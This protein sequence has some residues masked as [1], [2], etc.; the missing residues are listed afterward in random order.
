MTIQG[1]PSAEAHRAHAPA[2]NI[3]VCAECEKVRTILFL[4][5]DRW[6][7]TSCRNSGDARPTQVPVSNPARKGR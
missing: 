1:H 7:C 4:S 5:G 2:L 3:T 6:F